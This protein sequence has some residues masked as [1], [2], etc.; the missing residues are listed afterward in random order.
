MPESV[1]KLVND[2]GKKY[3]K[4]E[5]KESIEFRNINK[6]K[7]AWDNDEYEDDQLVIENDRKHAGPPAEFPG[8]DIDNEDDSP[9]MELLEDT[10]KERVLAAAKETGISTRGTNI[11]GLTTAV[12]L[13]DNSSD[14][15]NESEAPSLVDPDLSDDK[16]SDNDDDDDAGDDDQQLTISQ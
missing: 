13:I 10:D 9:A 2:W 11:E 4:T 3:Q 5:R 8:I 1:V 12:D 14:I 15:D 6:E 16:D 7:Y